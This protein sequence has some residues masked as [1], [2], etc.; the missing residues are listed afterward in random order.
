MK[1]KTLL[2][3]TIIISI[4]LLIINFT[5]A[6]QICMP[7]TDILCIN[8]R[9]SQNT[10]IFSQQYQIPTPSFNCNIDDLTACTKGCI[11]INV[12]G[13]MKGQCNT[14]TLANNVCVGNFKKVIPTINN[15]YVT[16]S[17]TTE[18]CTYGCSY[19]NTADNIYDMYNIG[20]TLINQPNYK[21]IC[22]QQTIFDITGAFCLNTN[23]LCNYGYY[24]SVTNQNYCYNGQSTSCTYG[25]ESGN[26]NDYCELPLQIIN[27]TGNTTNNQ[28][29][30]NTTYLSN[31]YIN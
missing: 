8:A 25:C 4:F 10:L 6:V 29:Y 28:T 5:T 20:Y 11:N 12:S 13:Q 30:I 9:N 31:I 15:G 22:N 16:G 24:S 3:S 19:Y 18:T 17:S 7:N 21:A 26:E 2:L 27:N 1:S 23:T 14:G